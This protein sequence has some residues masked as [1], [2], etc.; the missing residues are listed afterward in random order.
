[1]GAALLS[2][3]VHA[4]TLNWDANAIAPV[5]GGGGIWDTTATRWF[6]G[7][8][9]QAWN[10]GALSDAVF[11]GTA[12]TVT[13]GTPITVHN[14]TFNTTNYVLSGSTLTLGGANPTIATNATTTTINSIV[15]G[16]NGLIKSGTG[17]LVLAGVNTYSG[18]TVVQSG[19]LSITNNSALG[20]APNVAANF[21][22]ANG[23]T[24]NFNATTINRNF[25]LNGGVVNMTA[26]TGT[27]SGSPTLTA[28]TEL[29]LT[30]AGTFNSSFADSG[31]NVLS[32]TKNGAGTVILGGSNSYSG[33]TLVSA[34]ILRLSGVNALSA[35][36]NLGA[37]GQRHC[38]TGCGQSHQRSRYRRRSDSVERQRRIRR[39]R[40]DTH[41]QS[42]RRWLDT[43][44]GSNPG[45]HR[46]WAD[47]AVL[48]R[49][50]PTPASISAM[51]SISTVP[52]A[53]CRSTMAPTP[54]MPS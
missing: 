12:G 15:G 51:D 26:T 5:N 21:V 29:R 43:D 47:P 17:T 46:R 49:H 16:T 36:S 33:A 11:G 20:T 39:A 34:G 28:S 22:L 6:N 7:S 27:Y 10:N 4:Q 42:R 52:C 40:C 30:G 53:R 1:M 35:N 8:T 18:L 50:R 24:L 14:L 25:T 9:Y 38:R 13:L 3:S 41:R 19:T 54:P 23:A 31:A 44:M 2:V 32:L 37:V 45:I 48:V